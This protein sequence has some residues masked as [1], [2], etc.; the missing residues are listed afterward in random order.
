MALILLG[1]FRIL[2]GAF[3]CCFNGPF[4]GHVGSVDLCRGCLSPLSCQLPEDG[5]KRPRRPVNG[6]LSPVDLWLEV[7]QPGVSE[8]DMQV[9]KICDEERLDPFLFSLSDA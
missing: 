1:Y 3:L 4:L 6:A 7:V 8:N 2:W 9:P 5:F